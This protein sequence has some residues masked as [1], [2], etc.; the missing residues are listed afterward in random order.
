VFYRVAH[1]VVRVW[2]RLYLGFRTSGSERMPPAGPT[3]VA[4]NH[5]S[6]LDP[7]LVGISFSRRLRFAAKAELFKIPLFCSLIAALGSVPI[8]RGRPDRAGFR[9]LER[10]LRSGQALLV[11]PEGTR[12]PHGRL[13]PAEPGVGLLVLRTR[14]QV[15]PVAIVGSD[16]A[17]SRNSCVIRP[18]RVALKVGEPLSFH[19]YHGRPIDRQSAAEVADRIMQA[20][21]VLLPPDRRPLA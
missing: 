15:L 17:L 4:C 20:I 8:A 6:Y 18:A 14:A 13:L 21:S 10:I 11:F 5:L 1:T 7:P 12:S 2:A 9:R 16:R 3:I 19:E